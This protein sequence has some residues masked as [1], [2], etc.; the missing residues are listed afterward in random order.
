MS[1]FEKPHNTGSR[2]NRLLVRGIFWMLALLLHIEAIHFL[3]PK[4]VA[5]AP[6]KPAILTVELRPVTAEI[7]PAPPAPAATSATVPAFAADVADAALRTPAAAPP[8]PR[9]TAAPASVPAPVYHSV[10]ALTRHPELVDDAPE[11]I[12]I[13]DTQEGGSLVLRLLIDRHG[14]VNA[15]SVVRSTL[16]RE[17]EGRIVLQFYRARYRPG[18]ID[19]RPVNSE[20]LLDIALQ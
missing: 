4:F 12:A 3:G 11:E 14:V 2:A 20:L 17:L 1:L 18:E 13:A 8:R 16:P 10:D 5:I 7:Q 9:Q 15:V 19:G 6:G